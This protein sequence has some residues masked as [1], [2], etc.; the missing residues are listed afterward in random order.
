MYAGKET[1]FNI[2]IYARLNMQMRAVKTL[3]LL[4]NAT[5]D[6][7]CF[8]LKRILVCTLNAEGAQISNQVVGLKHHMR[9]RS[10]IFYSRVKLI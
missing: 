4:M 5:A 9:L 8:Q 3:P 1:C 6:A 2:L 7:G 10:L